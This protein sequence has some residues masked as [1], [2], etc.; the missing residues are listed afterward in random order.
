MAIVK[1]DFYTQ[2]LNQ[3]RPERLRG[4][5][6]DWGLNAWVL[7]VVIDASE[8]GTL[9]AGD[10]VKVCPTSTGKLKVVAGESTDRAVGYIIFNAKKESFKAGDHCSILLRGG[11]IECITE[12]ALEAGD[13]VA[14]KDADG[15]VTAT[16]GAGVQRMGMAMSA[17]TAVEGGTRVPVLVC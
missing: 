10:L 17:T 7:D 3:F 13:I 12:E 8:T 5:L 11:V 15:S 2:S 16:I 4:E 6:L 14:Y 9:Y 1:T